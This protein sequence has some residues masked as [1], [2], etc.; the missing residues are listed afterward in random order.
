VRVLQRPEARGTRW[1]NDQQETVVTAGEH[2]RA[3]G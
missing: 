2:E 3:A 1:S